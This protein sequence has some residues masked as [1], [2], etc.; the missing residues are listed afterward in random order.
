MNPEKTLVVP[1]A[2]RY[3]AKGDCMDEVESKEEKF[4]DLMENTAGA[5]NPG[6]GSANSSK[7]LSPDMVTRFRA[8]IARANFIVPDREDIGF[9]VKELARKMSPPVEND[10]EDLC[11]LAR[12]LSG[13]PMMN[14]WFEFQ[15]KP[16]VLIVDTDSG[17]AGC[18]RTRRS[19]CGGTIS[20]GNI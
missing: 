20:Y 5:R 2:R 8:V 19:T 3:D 10:L 15:E 16:E 7:P 1:G 6:L 17:W 11:R 4:Q 14:V 12:Y 13:R 9:S 18:R